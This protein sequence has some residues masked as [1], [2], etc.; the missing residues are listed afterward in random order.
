MIHTSF[1]SPKFKGLI[2]LKLFPGVFLKFLAA[3]LVLQEGKKRPVESAT[4][5]NLPQ[6]LTIG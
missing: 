6:I 5:K 1:L 2:L 3:H 4:Q